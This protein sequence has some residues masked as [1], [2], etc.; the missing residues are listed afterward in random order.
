MNS[1]NAKFKC[2]ECNSDK[3]KEH[4]HY[5]SKSGDSLYSK[6]LHEIQCGSCFMDIP[7]HLALKHNHISIQKTK[8]E[9]KYVYKPQHLKEAPKCSIC[10][11]YYYEVEKKLEKNQDKNRNIFLQKFTQTGNSDLIC[12]ICEPS[13][14]K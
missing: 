8:E 7:G 2:P 13:S 9:W 10:D 3:V 5:K 12:I 11:L 14:F 1:L 4:F 6:V